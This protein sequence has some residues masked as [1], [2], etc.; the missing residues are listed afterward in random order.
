M[1]PSSSCVRRSSRSDAGTRRNSAV[2]FP[3][4]S[5]DAKHALK[6]FVYVH[7]FAVFKI[8]QDGRERSFLK[9]NREFLLALAEGPLRAA[10]LDEVGCLTSEQIHPVEFAVTRC[11]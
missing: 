9:D 2:V 8:R 4:A 5:G 6:C 7:Q 1:P 10:A 11:V 3:I